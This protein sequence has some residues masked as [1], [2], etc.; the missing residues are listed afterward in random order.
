M[1]RFRAFE[2][3]T[4]FQWSAR[5]AL[6]RVYMIQPVVKPVVQP[7]WQ[8]AVSCK[9][10]SNR[11]SNRLT[12]WMFVYTIQPVVKPVERADCSFNTVVKPRLYNRFD[13]GLTYTRYS[14]LSNRLSNGFDNRL[15]VCIHVDNGFD[16]RFYRVYKH[17]PGCQTAWQ[18][19]WQQVVSCKRGFSIHK[20]TWFYTVGLGI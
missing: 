18:P 4:L 11:L 8:L 16:S 19:V 1:L 10:T 2:I 3:F 9:Q 7:V 17:L 6:N 13:N 15:N 14:R 20:V 5:R 12:G